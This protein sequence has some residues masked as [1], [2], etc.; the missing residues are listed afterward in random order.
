MANKPSF[1]M[2]IN[3]NHFSISH[4]NAINLYYSTKK[5]YFH[6]LVSEN[7]GECFKGTKPFEIDTKLK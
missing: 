3:I 1:F 5:R 2:P 7:G 4:K 6:A